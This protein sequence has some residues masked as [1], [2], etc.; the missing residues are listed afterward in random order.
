M[1]VIQIDV[2]VFW[3]VVFF[4]SSVSCAMVS[5]YLFHV[6]IRE[7]NAK[8]PERDRI[9]VLFGYPGLLWKVESLHR[10]FYPDSFLR[11]AL[12]AIVVAGVLCM[13]GVVA[14]LHLI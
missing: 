12:N 6:M 4:G 11:V 3:F 8:V 14:A 1:S 13:V 2:D 7:V 9:G 10:R 5:T